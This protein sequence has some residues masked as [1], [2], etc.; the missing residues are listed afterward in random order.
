MEKGWSDIS[1]NPA[2]IGRNQI[3]DVPAQIHRAAAEHHGPSFDT[4]R[5]KS[6]VSTRSVFADVI[7]C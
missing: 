4:T 7:C 1:K 3:H 6:F 2:E 5:G